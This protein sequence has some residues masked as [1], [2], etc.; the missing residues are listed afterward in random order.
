[1]FWERE[2]LRANLFLGKEHFLFGKFP[3]GAPTLWSPVL[4]RLIGTLMFGQRKVRSA[5]TV[6]LE[7]V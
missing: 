5:E 7:R 6:K 1:M 2:A 4:R 3:V